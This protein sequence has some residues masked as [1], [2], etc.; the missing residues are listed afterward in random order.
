M[1]TNSKK[2]G[3][4]QAETVMKKFFYKNLELVVFDSV[5]EPR[6]DSLLLAD[7]I[8]EQEAKGKIVL[9]LGCGTG[10]QGLN[11]LLLG[12]K[13]CF[14]ADIG[15]NALE[16][17]K[18][19]AQ[20]NCFENKSVFKKSD[21]FSALKNKKFGLII[22]NPP[23]VASGKKKKWLDTDGGKNGRE[24]LDSFLK[25]AKSH[26]EKDGRIVFVQSSLNGENKT[27]K[28]LKALGFKTRI[29][30]R[31]RLFFEELLVFKACLS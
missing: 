14:F 31:K 26:L 24:V 21:L 2:S 6:E 12:A 3:N 11:A 5:F 15:K 1:K 9:D 22:F 23:Y 13:K 7:A 29:V 27:K 18:E 30:A 25:Q 16:N 20:K 10:I 8:S 4:K 17:A 28:I 19:N